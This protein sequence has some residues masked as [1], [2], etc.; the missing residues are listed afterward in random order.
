[1]IILELKNNNASLESRAA[2]KQ[3]S[4]DAYYA[5]VQDFYGQIVVPIVV[6]K[7]LNNLVADSFISTPE[8]KGLIFSRVM[9]N[10]KNSEE[11]CRTLE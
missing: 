9:I 8:I 5:N 4:F 2:I 3:L 7:E 11:Q 6:S 10:P 1:M